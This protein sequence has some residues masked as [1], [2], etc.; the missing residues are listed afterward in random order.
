MKST[1]RLLGSFWDNLPCDN[2]NPKILRNLAIEC[3][4]HISLSQLLSFLSVDD[5][6]Q[7]LAQNEHNSSVVVDV[8]FVLDTDNKT[9]NTF[10]EKRIRQILAYLKLYY[11]EVYFYQER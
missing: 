7:F 6:E 4:H 3:A 9:I 5:I 11:D 2:D 10:F 8:D 1:Y